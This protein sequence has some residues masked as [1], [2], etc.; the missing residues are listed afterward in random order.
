MSH[1]AP[2]AL[3]TLPNLPSPEEIAKLAGGDNKYLP[4]LKIFWPI[5]DTEHTGKMCV[6]SGEVVTEL[7]EQFHLGMITGRA[8]IRHSN[9]EDDIFAVAY[10]GGKSDAK[11]QELA[12]L[13][14]T[15]KDVVKGVGYL[16]AVWPNPETCTIVV[17]EAFKSMRDYIAK[18]MNAGPVQNG[19]VCRMDVF[20]H[21]K[22]NWTKMQKGSGGY[23]DPK[24]FTQFDQEEISKQQADLMAAAM[25]ESKD[26]IDAWLAR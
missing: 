6:V 21:K 17:C 7:N 9:Q 4:R 22:A 24:K 14:A 3:A 11:Y 19:A 25:K 18:A 13:M 1:K 8:A 23:F 15:N 10:L 2:T 12:K 20:D 5:E 26:L 16:A